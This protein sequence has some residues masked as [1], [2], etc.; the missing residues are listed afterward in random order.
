MSSPAI[1]HS[2]CPLTWWIANEA[3][4]PN[5]TRLVRK[6]LA[7]LSTLVASERLFSKTGDIITKKFNRIDSCKADKIISL[8]ENFTA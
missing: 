2:V 7:M 5:I 8:V 1:D 6:L 4:Y 3:T